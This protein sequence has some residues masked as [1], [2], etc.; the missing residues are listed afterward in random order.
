MTSMVRILLLL[1]DMR[2]HNFK[3]HPHSR[4]RQGR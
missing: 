1:E 3:P 4:C 2:I